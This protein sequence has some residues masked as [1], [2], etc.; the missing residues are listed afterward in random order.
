MNEALDHDIDK[1][2]GFGRALLNNNGTLNTTTRNGQQLYQSLTSLSDAAADASVSAYA[3]AQQNG[4]PLP[5][6][7][8][9]A[10]TQMDKARTAAVRAAQGYGLTRE[11]AEAVADSLG[12]MPSKVSLLL[13][14]EG[15]DSTLA[16]LLAVQAEL[17]GCQGR[18]RSRAP[19]PS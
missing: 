6:S 7:L 5:E 11:Q 9:A 15:M 13:E 16:D 2:N 10:R 19:R 12:L 14:T 3:L 18:P 17:T 4:K 8:A 1:A